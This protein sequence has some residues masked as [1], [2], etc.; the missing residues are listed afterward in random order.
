[1]FQVQKFKVATEQDVADMSEM[2][3]QIQEIYAYWRQRGCSMEKVYCMISTAADQCVT[4]EAIKQE[5][6]R[7]LN[8]CCLPT[9]S[10]C[11]EKINKN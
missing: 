6:Q 4:V 1:M 5:T 9:S 10:C 3:R 2:Q 11:Q 7:Q 8:E